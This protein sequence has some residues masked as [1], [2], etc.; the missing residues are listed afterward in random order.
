MTKLE[1]LRKQQEELEI[2][3]KAAED[4]ERRERQNAVIKKIE[5][6][7][8][9]GKE[10]LLS[11]IEHENSSCSDDWPANGYY[12]SGYGPDAKKPRWDCKKCML[13]QILDGRHGGRFD[14]DISVEIKKV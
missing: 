5:S 9:E 6:I 7:T 8:P 4:E 1:M 12:I 10:A 2:Q 3:I 13:I 11:L 14:F